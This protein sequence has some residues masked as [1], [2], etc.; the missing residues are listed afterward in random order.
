MKNLLRVHNITTENKEARTGHSNHDCGRA[1]EAWTLT[2]T[3]TRL[4]HAGTEHAALRLAK[5]RFESRLASSGLI[6][7][8]PPVH[9]D[10]AD[11]N[12][13]LSLHRTRTM[14]PRLHVDYMH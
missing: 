12:T 9:V 13:K 1:H 3:T 5:L 10:D 8:D 6:L 11:G 7:V 2:Y 4:Q 14:T